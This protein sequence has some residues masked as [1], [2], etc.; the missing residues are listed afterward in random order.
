MSKE[1]DCPNCGT[2]ISIPEECLTTVDD[3][4][5]C[6]ECGSRFVIGYDADFVDGVWRD[7]T[8]LYEISEAKL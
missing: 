4:C 8:K 3:T 5:Q 2:P 7:L 6:S 1:Y